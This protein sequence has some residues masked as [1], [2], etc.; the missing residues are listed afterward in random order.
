MNIGSLPCILQLTSSTFS[1]VAVKWVSLLSLLTPLRSE[2]RELNWLL[3]GFG[4][5]T[6]L[7]VGP[8]CEDCLNR[9]ICPATEELMSKKSPKKP[10]P[11]KGKR[12]A[13]VKV[14]Q[15]P[16]DPDSK[17]ITSDSVPV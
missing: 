9:G 7:P 14:K 11:T 10:S 13:A 6:C 16:E 4:Q 12:T 15:E 17:P 2:W 5:Q 3:V 8:K 1:G